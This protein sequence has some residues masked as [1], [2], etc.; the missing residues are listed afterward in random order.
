MFQKEETAHGE[1]NRHDGLSVL[2]VSVPPPFPVRLGNGAC[3]GM[4]LHS[5]AVRPRGER[6]RS[7][8]PLVLAKLGSST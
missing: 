5:V 1:M 4:P 8:N 6:E 3:M 2:V 7:H